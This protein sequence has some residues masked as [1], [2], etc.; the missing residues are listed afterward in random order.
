MVTDIAGRDAHLSL[1]SP[2]QSADCARCS[3][4]APGGTAY[5]V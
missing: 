2:D 5:L 3:W 1:C 4:S